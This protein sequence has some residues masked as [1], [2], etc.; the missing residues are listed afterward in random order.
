MDIYN[1][2]L[3]EQLL[4][5]KYNY[6]MDTYIDTI[7]KLIDTSYSLRI[8]PFK[9]M[10]GLGYIKNYIQTNRLDILQNGLDY[11]LT[12][13][14][15][16]LNFDISNLNELDEDFDDNVSIKSCINNIKQSHKSN[17][18]NTTDFI[19]NSNDMLNLIIEIKNNAKKLYKDDILI[20]KNY[21]ELLIII[22][23]NINKL[24]N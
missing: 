11:I 21:F 2:D 5:E 24:F 15:T 9:I 1:I 12:N 20:I 23:E 3:K 17:Q 19:S 6:L 16:I 13:K 4:F 18:S 10:F 14:E 8:L 22:L 7:I